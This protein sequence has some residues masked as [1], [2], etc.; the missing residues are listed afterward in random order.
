MK[1]LVHKD[2]YWLYHL[3]PID[4][5]ELSIPIKYL[6]EREMQDYFSTECDY[7]PTPE[8]MI[9]ENLKVT[10]QRKAMRVIDKWEKAKHLIATELG[11]EGDYRLE[12]CAFVV[13]IEG[14][15]DVGFVIK[16]DNNG[17]TFVASPVELNHLAHLT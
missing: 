15:F 9:A 7:L 4:W 5:F 1:K 16:Q 14:A 10:G 2:G 8:Y 6:A 12:P 13:P 3:P 11:W 17:C